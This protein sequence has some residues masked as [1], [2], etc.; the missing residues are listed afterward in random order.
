MLGL[1]SVERAD[2]NGILEAIKAATTKHTRMTED[3]WI[4]KL[5][6]F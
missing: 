1:E 5:V 3:E 4:G 2:A 6:A